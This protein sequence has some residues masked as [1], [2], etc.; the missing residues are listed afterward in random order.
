MLT[1]IKSLAPDGFFRLTGKLFVFFLEI[2]A[3]GVELEV[4]GREKLPRSAYLLC[5][6]HNGNLDV[7]FIRR[8]MGSD[9]F[10]NK[11]C[12][13]LGRLGPR[14]SPF[15]RR[16]WLSLG[17]HLI[18]DERRNIRALREA[19]RSLR[20]GNSLILFPERK[21]GVAYRG[22]AYLACESSRPVVPV[23]IAGGGFLERKPPPYA[24]P[25]AVRREYIRRGGRVTVTI[26]DP[27]VPDP[28]RYRR[29]GKRY[30]DELTQELG[31]KLGVLRSQ[32]V[33]VR[34]ISS[35]DGG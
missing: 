16:M 33:P 18:V 10:R 28:E 8:V 5:P 13:A 26:M 20:E 21:N 15:V 29:G 3:S 32:A 11:R 24:W 22:A 30:L 19:L 35:G 25:L 12:S 27:I 9:F 7:V 6:N 4:K 31:E 17:I 2:L 1:G 34:T 14:I 23:R